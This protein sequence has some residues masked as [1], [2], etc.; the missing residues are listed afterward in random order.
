MPD[1]KIIVEVSEDDYWDIM[2][3]DGEAPCQANIEYRVHRKT[4]ETDEDEDE[5]AA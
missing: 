2:R 5:Q 3:L 1:R 4:S